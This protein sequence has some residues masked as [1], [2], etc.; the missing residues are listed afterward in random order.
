GKRRRLRL[1]QVGAE[2]LGEPRLPLGLAQEEVP[3]RAGFKKRLERGVE[4][5]E[6]RIRLDEAALGVEDRD[7]VAQHRQHLGRRTLSLLRHGQPLPEAAA[8]ANSPSRTAAAAPDSSAKPW[9]SSVAVP[10][11]VASVIAAV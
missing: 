7:A 3:R 1:A 2:R 6:R 8:S 10:A 9:S 4:L 11:S 5:A